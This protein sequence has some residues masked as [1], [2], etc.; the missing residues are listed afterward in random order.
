M[1]NSF[2]QI[3][4]VLSRT[5]LSSHFLRLQLQGPLASWTCYPGAY[6][7]LLLPGAKPNAEGQMKNKVRT[8]TIRSLDREREVL[9]IDFALHQPAGPATQWALNAQVGDSIELK[10]P[11]NLKFDPAG[12]DWYLFAADM[13]ALPAALA[14]MESLDPAAQGFAILEITDEQDQQDLAIPEGIEVTWLIHPHPESSSQQQL[15]AIKN[16]K[17]PEG[18][19]NI[20]VAGE[21]GTIREIKQ[22]LQ[23]KEL[24]GPNTYISSYWKI[25]AREEEHKEAKRAL[26]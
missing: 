11:G 5:P 4:K 2:P 13:A 17:F 25:G 14:V 20:F 3:F 15:N 10:G 19:P 21:L 6:V 23:E 16:L 7:K 18:E 12:G 26:V 9:T 1:R 22:Y 8:Y 24:P